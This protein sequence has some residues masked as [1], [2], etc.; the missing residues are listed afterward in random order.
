MTPPKGLFVCTFALAAALGCGAGRGA[1]GTSVT[2]GETSSS[3]DLPSAELVSTG[4]ARIDMPNGVDCNSP[5]IWRDGTFVQFNSW[6]GQPRIG[7]GPDLSHLTPAGDA[8]YTN[9]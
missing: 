8:H 6:G 1:W 4:V 5:S 9:R 7:R 2:Q 3:G